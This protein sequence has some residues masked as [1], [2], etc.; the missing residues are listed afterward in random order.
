M[1]SKTVEEVP[2]ADVVLIPTRLQVLNPPQ[3]WV[4]LLK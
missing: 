3:N 4:S 2:P 1:N